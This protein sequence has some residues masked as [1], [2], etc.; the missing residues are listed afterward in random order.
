[1]SHIPVQPLGEFKMQYDNHVSGCCGHNALHNIPESATTFVSELRRMFHSES[2]SSRRHTRGAY[3]TASL[4]HIQDRSHKL[5]T[6]FGFKAM[7]TE[8]NTNSGNDCTVYVMG[9]S[10]FADKINAGID[11][12]WDPKV[13]LEG[14]EIKIS[15]NPFKRAARA[16]KAE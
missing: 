12:D 7:Y 5:L 8:K 4:N 9:Q 13:L 1:M 15:S 11:S 10:D 6:Q 3:V 16:R 14:A 2:A